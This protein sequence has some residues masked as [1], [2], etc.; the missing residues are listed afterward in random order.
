MTY[1]LDETGNSGDVVVRPGK[2]MFGGQP[3]FA[4]A[5]VGES[6]GS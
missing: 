3:V 2:K 6:P 1:Y 4:L 5:A